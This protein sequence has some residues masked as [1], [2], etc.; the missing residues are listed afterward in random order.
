MC[1]SHLSRA[2]RLSTACT[3]D[4]LAERPVMSAV[5]RFNLGHRSF[6]WSKDPQ[7]KHLRVPLAPTGVNRPPLFDFGAELEPNFCDG[8][9]GL[10]CPA[11]ALVTF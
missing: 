3:L 8:L 11:P 10:Y 1:E 9:G 5:G 2:L 7:L 4:T 6:K